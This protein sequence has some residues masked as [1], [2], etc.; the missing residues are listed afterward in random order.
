M[1]YKYLKAVANSLENEP[2]K[3]AICRLPHDEMNSYMMD[4]S[5][6]NFVITDVK[7]IDDHTVELTAKYHKYQLNF[8]FKYFIKIC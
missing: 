8:P 5:P 2:T 7:P 3:G 6:Y 4:A 1:N